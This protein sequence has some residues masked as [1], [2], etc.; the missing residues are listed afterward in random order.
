MKFT[1]GCWHTRAGVVID[2]ATEVFK[3][4][5]R[6]DSL[7]AMSCSKPINFRG[8]TLNNPTLTM[9]VTSPADNTLRLFG[10]HWK[11]QANSRKGPFF[12]LFPD[13]H[14]Q[15][16]KISTSK[17]ENGLHMDAGPLSV[18]INTAKKSYGLEIKGDGKLLT[19]LGWRSFG[20]IKDNT[21]ATNPQ[22]Q[23]TDP[24]K[25]SRYTTYQF[26]LSVGEKIYGLGE[27][28]GPLIRNGQSID[29]FNEDGGTGS[30]ISYKNVPFY[31]SNRGYGVFIN[32]SARL[33][34][35]FQS[36]RTARVNIAIPGE[37]L[38][39]YIVYGPSPKEIIDR[40][41]I[42]TGR[43]ALPPIWTLGLWMSTSFTT[44]YDENT[45]NSFIDGLH[46]REIDFDVF[47]Y[48]CFW[49]KGF[50]WCDFE[51]DAEFFPDAKAQLARLKQRGKHIC[52][53]IN[54]Y[55]AQES[56]LFDEGAK[57]GYFLKTPDGGVWQ[58]DFWQAGMG[59]V[60]FTNPEAVAWYQSKLEALCDIGVDSF[61]TDFGERIPIG[62]VVY[63]DGSD[64]ARMHNYYPF[65]YNKV[66]FE[67]LLKK[68]GK[69]HAAVFARSATAGV[70]RFPVHWGGDPFSTYE[71]MS[72][73]LRGGIS[74]GLTGFGYW[75]HDI[76]GFEGNP[77]PG[78]Y[79]R[80]I[81][82]GLLS[83]HSRLHGSGSFRAPW[84]IDSTGEADKV[85]K[86]FVDNKHTLRSYIYSQ[87]LVA[88]TRGTPILRGMFLE[89]EKDPVCWNLD[90]QYMLGDRLLVAPVFNNE[91]DV[92]YYVPAGKWYGILDGKFRE[93]PGYISETH[94]YF[95][96]PLLL[97]PG[98]AIAIGQTKREY[99]WTDGLTVLVNPAPGSTT[100]MTVVI[101]HQETLGEVAA[102]ITLS[103]NGRDISVKVDGTM[104]SDWRIKIAGSD[105]TTTVGKSD[106]AATVTY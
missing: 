35:E 94:D 6:D 70:Q 101:P 33:S 88:H 83:S 53:W 82:F 49:M 36:E 96:I 2:W 23:Y 41:T 72:E 45:V 42:L 55:I 77:D 90:T 59:F 102:T 92:Q 86:H 64:P 58:Y 11:A 89:F 46:D 78:L 26:Q 57:N 62:N 56:K 3:G 8:D 69:N 97:R 61:K 19:K 48:D 68:Y 40:Y 30:D 73:Q 43:P 32:S 44:N 39:A 91:G 28:F 51:F 7:Y 105:S 22:A 31:I 18:D 71:A 24:L 52:V 54:S 63:H 67:V 21:N 17:S 103:P 15:N 99:D 47:H 106:V 25:G 38:D 100:D 16:N 27:K 65:L 29:L 12:E 84:L 76:G 80:W 93:G 5:A 1:D 81:A 50:Q 66:V 104:K 98:T 4:E 87:A 14:P 37:E 79:K 34:Y 10:Y 95:S 75:A 9:E 74:L 85:L 60:D 20:Y 13:E